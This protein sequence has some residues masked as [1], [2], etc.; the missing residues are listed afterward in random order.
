MKNIKTYGTS[1]GNLSTVIRVGDRNMRIRFIS[2]DNIHGFYATTDVEL[3]KAIE[4]DSGYGRKFYL[5][6]EA[7]PPCKKKT[8]LRPITEVKT[9]QDAKELL[10]KKPYSVSERDLASPEKIEKAARK[11][12][13]MFP[14]L[15]V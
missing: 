14:A 2:K 10:S 7:Q 9:W 3:Q 12:G 4:S 5:I 13:I 15:K 8:D 1:H 6:E 11:K